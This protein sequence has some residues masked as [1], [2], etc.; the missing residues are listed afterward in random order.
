MRACIIIACALGA[1]ALVQP[2]TR[3]ASAR[4]KT[5]TADAPSLSPAD[6][7]SRRDT[8]W[9]AMA[10]PLAVA[11]A[12]LPGAAF[13]KFAPGSQEEKGY[14]DCLSLCAYY[15]M[16]PKGQFTKTRAECLME[17]KPICK[18]DPKAKFEG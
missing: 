4:A 17:C 2:T 18:A 10:L 7:A 9:N 14:N 13:A 16:K 1:S 6:V 12:A 15:C 8:L 3:G 11:T 5:C